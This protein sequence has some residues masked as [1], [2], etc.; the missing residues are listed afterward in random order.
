MASTEKR[1]LMLMAL[2][3]RSMLPMPLYFWRV[4]G[5]EKVLRRQP[6]LLRAHRWVSRRSLLL[7]SWW[8]DR[9]VAEA[10]LEHPAHQKML[11]R[12]WE[13]PGVALWVELYEL[14]LGAFH[15]RARGAP[16]GDSV[17][18]EQRHGQ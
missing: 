13:S 6:G 7:M 3:L 18:A 4:R 11:Q 2:H 14:A 1:I 8:R 16:E 5:L 15:I 12:V 17:E 9:A 10:W